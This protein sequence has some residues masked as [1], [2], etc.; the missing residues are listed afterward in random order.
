MVAV[1]LIGH[2]PLPWY[3]SDGENRG[4]VTRGVTD[5][6]AWHII[7]LGVQPET[8]VDRGPFSSAPLDQH[9]EGSKF[10]APYISAGRVVA[11][12][13]IDFESVVLAL[14][15]A[16][17]FLLA[18]SLRVSAEAFGGARTFGCS[19]M[20]SSPHAWRLRLCRILV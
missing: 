10:D 1:L 13:G 20:L 4:I 7:L 18:A 6:A 5:P 9:P 8:D 2:I 14:S 17:A 12:R 11:P 19:Y 16:G 3:D 15:C